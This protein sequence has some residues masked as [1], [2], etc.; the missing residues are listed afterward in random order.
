MGLEFEENG[1]LECHF[2]ECL[3]RNAWWSKTPAWELQWVITRQDSTP[4]TGG[5]QAG[6][7]SNPHAPHPALYGGGDWNCVP[8]FVCEAL[9]MSGEVVPC[10][11]MAGSY[12]TLKGNR[13]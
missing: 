13:A 3:W 7:P 9:G 11:C 12:W 1:P 8:G 10:D 6:A 2:F 4:G 5:H